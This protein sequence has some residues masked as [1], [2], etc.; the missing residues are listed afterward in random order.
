[1]ASE[2]AAIEWLSTGDEVET[3]A[4]SRGQSRSRYWLLPR[5]VAPVGLGVALL[6]GFVFIVDLVA[7]ERSQTQFS[8]SVVRPEPLHRTPRNVPLATSIVPSGEG[9]V[10]QPSASPELDE[11]DIVKAVPVAA[12][13]A[14]RPGST[15]LDSAARNTAAA[16]T[17]DPKTLPAAPRRVT[18]TPAPSV[19]QAVPREESKPVQAAVAAKPAPA[20]SIE[21]NAVSAHPSGD[22]LDGMRLL[23]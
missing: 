5:W 10:L 8:G 4:S 15:A 19:T 17:V 1:P 21:A 18:P 11:N 13:T 23:E 6:L 12:P 7:Q 14:A 2:I 20:P 3:S 22:T 16:P 9:V